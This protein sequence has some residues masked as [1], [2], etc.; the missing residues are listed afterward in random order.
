M[1]K[2]K[3][4]DL[5]AGIG[6]IRMGFDNAFGEDIETV[7]VSEWDENAQKTYSANFDDKFSIAGDITKIDPDDLPDFDM[8]MGGFPCQPFSISGKQRGFEDSRG[9][10]FFD[11]ARIVKCK[12][13]KIVFMENVY[14]IVT[15]FT[16]FRSDIAYSK[17]FVYLLYYF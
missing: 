3:S 15:I 17:Y 6:G 10:L 7:F 11:V 8:F 13:P 5:F 4:I 2:F 9:T 16:M 14:K 12:K 1:S